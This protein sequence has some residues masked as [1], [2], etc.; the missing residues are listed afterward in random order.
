MKGGTCGVEGAGCPCEGR[1]DDE[2]LLFLDGGEG[3]IFSQI[4]TFRLRFTNI[5]HCRS[6]QSAVDPSMIKFLCA[7]KYV[8]KQEGSSPAVSMQQELFLAILAPG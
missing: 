7:N 3:R 5:I 4:A 6:I 8:S 2:L 1:L